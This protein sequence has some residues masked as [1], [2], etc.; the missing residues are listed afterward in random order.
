MEYVKNAE[1]NKVKNATYQSLKEALLI[2]SHTH[3]KYIYFASRAE[4]EGFNNIARL[5]RAIAFSEHAQA[6]EL[7]RLL[8]TITSTKENL[9]K[10]IHAENSKKN[11]IYPAYKAIAGKE[12]Q[13]DAEKIFDWGVESAKVHLDLCTQA[14]EAADSGKDLDIGEIYVCLVCGWMAIAETPERCPLCRSL[15]NTFVKF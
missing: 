8:G 13:E 11:E 10:A 3:T 15:K 9:D 12:K 2:K 14:K 1:R 6:G 4:M 7:F 5:F